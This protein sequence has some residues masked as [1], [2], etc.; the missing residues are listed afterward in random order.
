[1]PQP[2]AASF[3]S[4]HHPA[5]HHVAA[6]GN[7]VKQ[8]Q[9]SH[10]SIIAPGHQMAGVALQIT[11]VDFLVGTFLFDHEDFGPQLQ[12]AVQLFLAQ[13]AVMFAEPV[14][15]HSR[16]GIQSVAIDTRRVVDGR[17][18]RIFFVR[19]GW[20]WKVLCKGF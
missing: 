13:V 9:V 11:P 1:M 14:G 18:S 7:R 5:D 16:L 3:G 19:Q 2:L 6:L 17:Q 10:Q 20:G 15:G 8:A 12:D 4:D